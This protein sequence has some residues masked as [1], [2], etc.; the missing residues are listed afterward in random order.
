MGWVR[1]GP[2]ALSPSAYLGIS[3]MRAKLVQGLTLS[4]L[5]ESGEVLDLALNSLPYLAIG[6][7]VFSGGYIRARVW[8]TLAHY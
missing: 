8:G 7:G 3:L 1:S 4:S 2:S 5:L 6:L